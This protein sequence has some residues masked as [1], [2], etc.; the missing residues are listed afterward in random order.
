MSISM[1]TASL[2][3]FRAAK[4][5]FA[6]LF[7]LCF[8]LVNGGAAFALGIDLKKIPPLKEQPLLP[9]AQFA[10]KT[11]EVKEV[12]PY[13]DPLLSYSFRV[14]KGWTD[15]V[16]Q[17]PVKEE[18]APPK[19]SGTVPDILGRYIA[20][21]KNFERSRVAVEAQQMTYEISAL[22]WFVNFILENGFS[23][24]AITEKSAREIEALY[25]AVEEDKT[26]VVRT[27]VIING[28]RLILVRHHLPQENYEEEK[29]EQA[30]IVKS[31]TLLNPSKDRI[32]KQLTYGFLD[33]SYFNYPESWTLKER[34]ILSI[35]RMS[36]L[37]YQSSMDEKITVLDGH[38]KVDVVSRLL[39]TTLPQ[40]VENFRKD[41]KVPGYKIGALIEDI[42]YKFNASIESGKGQA[43]KLVPD[44]PV[45]MKEYEVIVS[46][47]QGKDFYYITSMITPSRDQNFYAW[48]RNMEA[49]R[50]VNETLRRDAV[51]MEV[52]PNDPYFDYLKKQ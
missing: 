35:E 28:P 19:L 31:F 45:R 32:E 41:F 23:L 13:A 40:E 9:E 52:D 1:K 42:P 27:R 14:P 18:L 25:V 29:V 2:R 43:Y 47:M 17:R 12:E 11:K 20:A 26:F 21:P 16:Q 48:A 50:I 3:Q 37:L 51:T 39:G 36:A 5:L 24:T 44:D 7:V 10:A 49:I 8:V 33:Q 6:V 38:I 46:I 34:S 4:R 15:N 22:N 30:Q